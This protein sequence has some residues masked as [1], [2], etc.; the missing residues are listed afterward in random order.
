MTMTAPT[1]TEEDWVVC[2]GET[3][4]VT[5]G[6]VACPMRGGEP[7]A[8]ETCAECHLLSWH[9]DERSFGASCSVG[10][11]DTPVRGSPRGDLP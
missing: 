9:H 11:D 10:P 8:V 7:V 4:A 2:L 3:R 1:P 5:D 6:V